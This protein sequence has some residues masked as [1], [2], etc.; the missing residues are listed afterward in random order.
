ML[1]WIIA[2]LLA[3]FVK[4]LCGFANTLVFTSVLSL[5]NDNIAISPV[6]LLLGYPTNCI[7]AFRERKYIR[8]KICIP[9]SILVIIGS[10]LGVVLLKNVD[11]QII[12]I[13]CGFVLI[14][15]AFE[16]LFRKEQKECGPNSR[17]ILY[18]IGFLSGILCGL[19]GI[20]AL[21]GAYFAKITE[22]S[23]EF[24][25]NICVVFLVENTF[26]I[27]LYAGLAI[28]NFK[29]LKTFLLLVPF[30]LLGLFC[31]MKSSRMLNE[32]I[33]GKIVVVMILVSGVFLIVAN[34]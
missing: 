25:A 20:G 4:G 8:A 12:K 34:M 32:Q 29:V 24:K 2:S 6:E 19:Y 10:M 16:M 28:I 9:I 18:L 31:G 5:G 3:F 11:G 13:A 21:L 33:V 17:I 7:I 14:I 26:R 23:K 22:D 27:I 15:V 30:M 1:I